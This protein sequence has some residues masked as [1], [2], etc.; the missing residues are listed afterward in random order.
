MSNDQSNIDDE[1]ANLLARQFYLHF[2]KYKKSSPRPAPFVNEWCLDYADMAVR[3]LLD[4]DPQDARD[5]LK[6]DYR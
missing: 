2:H 1:V 5:D 3:Y 6:E 4:I